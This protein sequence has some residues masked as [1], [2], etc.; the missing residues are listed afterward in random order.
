MPHDCKGHEISVGDIVELRARVTH[1][2][3]SPDYCNM[4]VEGIHGAEDPRTKATITI[5]TR[6]V[7]RIIPVA[8]PDN[9]MHVAAT[10]DARTLG[11]R[12]S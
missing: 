12:V 7:E 11:E 5:N 2:Y 1:I 6:A 4:T 3:P 9:A 8:V 10:G